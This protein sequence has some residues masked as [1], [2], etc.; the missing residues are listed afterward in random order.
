MWT[1]ARYVSASMFSIVA[2][3]VVR[4]YFVEMFKK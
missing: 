3:A 4:D 2:F 1:D